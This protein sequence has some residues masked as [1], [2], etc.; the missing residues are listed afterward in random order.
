MVKFIDD[1][2]ADNPTIIYRSSALDWEVANYLEDLGAIRQANDHHYT[3]TVFA[4][5][6]RRRL[7]H[8]RLAWFC[9]NW[10]S[11]GVLLVS[12]LVGVGTIISN[13]I[14]QPP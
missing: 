10:F 1:S 6:V 9:D 3:L 11:V 7:N 8:P 4:P 13:F 14:G 5:E 12:L 2:L